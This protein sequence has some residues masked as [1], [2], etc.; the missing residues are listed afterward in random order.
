MT[1]PAGSKLKPLRPSWLRSRLAKWALIVYT[2]GLG[3]LV[4]KK[5][6]I[7]TTR[8]EVSGKRWR[9]PLWYLRD[10][11]AIYCISGW[12]PSSHWLKNVQANPDVLIQ[13]GNDKKT[14][15]GTLIKEPSELERVLQRFQNKYGRRMVNIFY[16]MDRLV[17][18]AFTMEETAAQKAM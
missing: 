6:L 5:V 8:G 14:G 1:T 2:L 16:H 3:A 10:N 11:E 15:R 7:L 18:V 12:G 9:T 17:L 4:G 13:I